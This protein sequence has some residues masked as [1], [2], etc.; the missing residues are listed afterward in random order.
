LSRTL[1][2]A[3][4][5]VVGFSRP[6]LGPLAFEVNRGERLGVWGPPG[7]GKS[8]LI[9]A[10]A[11]GAAVFDGRIHRAT[12]LAMAYQEQ[13]PVRPRSL[14]MTVREYLAL[15]GSRAEAL[16]FLTETWQRQRV[17]GLSRHQFQLLSVWAALG[18]KE[19]DLI[20]LDEPAGSLNALDRALLADLLE[21]HARD[22][23]LLVASV[24]RG[25]LV[26]A[27]AR[28]MEVGAGT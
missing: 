14:P 26:R 13:H 19:A 28:V 21:Q 23:G 1:V 15:A 10:I 24:D 5:L 12:G 2:L 11:R 7:S 8:A 22:R 6:V 16:P 9:R 18:S 4:G 17:D 25:F 27:C 3:A 20:L